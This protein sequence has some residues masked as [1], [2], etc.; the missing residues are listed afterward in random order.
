MLAI[1][2]QDEHKNCSNAIFMYD[3]K[4][5]I[6]TKAGSMRHKRSACLVAV[7]DG[8]NGSVMVVVGGFIRTNEVTN[9]AEVIV[10]NM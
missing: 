6:W 10:S 9:A 1:G 8:A 3:T 5:D 4:L 7:P 2:G